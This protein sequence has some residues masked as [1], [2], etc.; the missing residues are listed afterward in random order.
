MLFTKKAPVVI[1]D[2]VFI[3]AHCLILKGVTIGENSVIG[4]VSIVTKNTPDNEI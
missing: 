2:N 4:A 1:K 3:G